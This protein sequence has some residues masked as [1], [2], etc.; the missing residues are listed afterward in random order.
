MRHNPAH[1]LT[2]REEKSMRFFRRKSEHELVPCPQCSK[3]LRAD[4]VECD[5]CGAD[6]RE[7]A[8]VQR[9]QPTTREDD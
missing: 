9:T 1:G 3:L 7:L 5:L 8:T 6:L 4:A 2:R